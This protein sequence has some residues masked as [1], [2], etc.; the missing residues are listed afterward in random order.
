MV[1]ISSGKNSRNNLLD[2]KGLT[3]P[4]SNDVLRHFLVLLLYI[5]AVI[6]FS[7]PLALNLTDHTFGT[8]TYDRDQNF[9]TLWWV[10]QALTNY[11]V[12]PFFTNFVYYPTGV[13]L[14]L[15]PTN[16]VAGIISLPLQAVFG[17]VPAF[18]LLY[19]LGIA[20]GAWGIYCLAFYLTRDNIA[21]FMAGL[22]FAFAP[23]QHTATEFNQLNIVQYQW[24]AFFA[25]WLVKYLDWLFPGRAALRLVLPLEEVFRNRARYQ[26]RY[27]VLSA[28]FLLLIAFTDQY[29]L[30]FAVFLMAWLSVGPLFKLLVKKDWRE[31]GLNI[32]KLGLVAVPVSI[33]FF[34]VMVGFVKDA[35]SGAFL[36]TANSQIKGMDFLSLLAPW[37]V[38]DQGKV[39]QLE[40][41]RFADPGFLYSVGWW[42]VLGLAI[43]AAWKIRGARIWGGLALAGA[44]LALGN[45]LVI[46]TWDTG[47]PLFGLLISKTPLLQVMHYATRWLLPATIG[48]AIGCGYGL[49]LLR[50]RLRQPAPAP[51]TENE[52]TN[53]ITPPKRSWGAPRLLA[54]PL[55][56][57]LSVSA[58]QPYPIAWN[59]W[60]VPP[61]PPAFT[62]NVLTAPGAVLDLPFDEG[63]RDKS[64]NMRYQ[65]IHGRPIVEGY[66]ARQALINY[67]ATP[68]AYFFEDYPIAAKDVIQV[69]P[70]AVQSLL[71]Y[72]H[73]AYIVLDKAV[74][75]EQRQNYFRKLIEQ[76]IGPVKTSCTYEDA[77][78]LVCPVT[79]PPNPVPFLALSQGWYE[80]EAENGGQ[81]W[82]R[83][84]EGFVGAFVPAD[85]TY[86][87]N[88]EGAAYL[89][90][91]HLTVEIDGQPQI[92][93]TIAPGRQNYSLE[94]KLSGGNH[95][96][97]L[98]SP[99]TPDR[100]SNNGSPADT[101]TLTLLFSQ[102]QLTGSK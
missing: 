56:I 73:F 85:G 8:L 2:F 81:R 65:T 54:V 37:G 35:R 90:E 49:A 40:R 48:L 28:L 100:P 87:L 52:T 9:W 72:Y 51:Q 27:G 98:Y 39:L 47:L 34:R 44:V 14:Y 76:G 20:G 91:R 61:T 71:G 84:Q 18:N 68:F 59:L 22:I 74:L 50:E 5:V 43:Y 94:L 60:A 41:G 58:L 13:N 99:E 15:F 55:V 31:L 101:R 36:E 69:K 7:W 79:P 25:Y 46:S 86:K 11:H 93:A 82:L 57:V 3:P 70:E 12:T 83:G 21:A 4:R 63:N 89:K 67:G 17:L 95:I 16:L 19:F 88:F 97:R 45:T 6:A 75:P 10:K 53:P 24:I 92:Q 30:L 1:E 78:S 77:F 42:A 62:K 80:P 26:W 23:W 38:G 102:L 66:L 32:I 29:H 96:M 33:A 64:D